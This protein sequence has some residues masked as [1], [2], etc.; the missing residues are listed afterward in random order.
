MYVVW[1]NSI[2]S[3]TEKFFS[4]IGNKRET[5]EFCIVWRAKD[6]DW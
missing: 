6:S 2:K 4:F 3:V 5:R 1:N